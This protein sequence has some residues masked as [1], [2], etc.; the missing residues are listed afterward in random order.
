MFLRP[1]NFIHLALIL[2]MSAKQCAGK[3]I[4]GPAE[5]YVTTWACQER[6]V[7]QGLEMIVLKGPVLF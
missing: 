1:V 7:G 5:L 4:N 6:N 2:H 3:V